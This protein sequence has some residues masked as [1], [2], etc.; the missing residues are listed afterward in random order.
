M[1]KVFTFI[2]T[3]VLILSCSSAAFAAE[4]ITKDQYYAR[5]TLSGNELEYYDDVYNYLV[6]DG[7]DVYRAD[8]DINEEDYP[9]YWYYVFGDAPEAFNR[10]QLYSNAEVASLNKQIQQ[11]SGE[12]L[13]LISDNMSDYEKVKSLYIY[14]STHITYDRK[15]EGL[16]NKGEKNL[17]TVESQTIVGG[18][19]NGEAVCGGI[20]SSYQYLLYQVGI[21][22]YIVSG[23][24]RGGDHAWNIVQIDGQWYH[25]D[26]TQD[27]GKADGFTAFL[28]S[29]SIIKLHHTVESTDGINYNPPLPECPNRYIEPKPTPTP[30]PTVQPTTIAAAPTPEATASPEP[31]ETD[32]VTIHNNTFWPIV[33]GIAAAAIIITL[34]VRKKKK[35]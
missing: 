19:I 16:I 9:R 29:D 15:A 17:Q 34:L 22:C 28:V 6:N 5:S 30:A 25:C 12:I 8:Y 11:K 33:G 26:L 20:A 31:V 35:A 2:L 3:T 32:S 27:L 18:F 1:K 23:T 10:Q 7:S 4:P 21:P 14:L 24:R 13:N